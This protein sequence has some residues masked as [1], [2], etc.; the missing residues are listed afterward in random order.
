MGL[1]WGTRRLSWLRRFPIISEMVCSSRLL[2]LC[3][4][5][6]KGAVS[7]LLSA[8]PKVVSEHR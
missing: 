2:I 1:V 8:L 3:L 6:W 4:I 7:P 5:P